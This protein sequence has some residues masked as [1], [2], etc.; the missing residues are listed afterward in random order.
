[1]QRTFD[2]LGLQQW[3]TDENLAAPIEQLFG[4]EDEAFLMLWRYP[5]CDDFAELA[6][7]LGHLAVAMHQHARYHKEGL[8]LC[9]GDAGFIDVGEAH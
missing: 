2:P 7:N 3:I 1:M 8:L 4:V 9:V 5:I 6:T